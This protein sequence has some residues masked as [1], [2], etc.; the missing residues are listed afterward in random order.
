MLIAMIGPSCVGKS[1]V[2]LELQQGHSFRFLKNY[3]TRQYRD[4][5]HTKISITEK[6]FHQLQDDDSLSFVN[7]HYSYKYAY[8]KT[9]IIQAINSKNEYYMIDFSIQNIQ[10]LKVYK[11]IKSFIIIPESL[12]M[13]ASRVLKSNRA[14]RFDR[15]MNEYEIYYSTLKEG[16]DYEID[17]YVMI[18]VENRLDLIVKSI[19]YQLAYQ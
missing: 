3:T 13:F 12:E 16:Y 7:E 17:A 8:S 11:N 2:M 9:D 10:Q 5:K 19:V 18:N 15:I 1:T 4:E 14:S 6:E